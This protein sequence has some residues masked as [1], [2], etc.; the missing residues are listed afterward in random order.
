MFHCSCV[1]NTKS[2]KTIQFSFIVCYK[3]VV[4][5][6]ICITYNWYIYIWKIEMANN[7]ME[8][9]EDTLFGENSD[10][11]DDVQD[12]KDYKGK[13]CMMSAIFRVKIFTGN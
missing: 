5:P 10:V 4:N 6:I 13:C 2:S 9:D 3:F 12:G 11:T 1:L 8:Y 7:Y